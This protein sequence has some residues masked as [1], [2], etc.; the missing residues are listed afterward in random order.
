MF[1]QKISLLN[2]TIIE[3]LNETDENKI[4][5]A[6]TKLANRILDASFG[7]VWFRSYNSEKFELIYK[8]P[9]MPYDPKPPRTDGLNQIAMDSRMPYYVTDV[10]AQPYTVEVGPYMK[11][12]VIIPITHHTQVY[13]NIVL[14][15]QKK[16]TFPEEKKILCSFIGNSV[17][18]AISIRRSVDS[19]HERLRFEEENERTRFIANAAHELRTPLAIIKGNVD[20]ALMSKTKSLPE[21]VNALRAIDHEVDRLKGLISDMSLLINSKSPAKME[22][23]FS[24]IDIGEV[25]ERTVDR[26]KA[27]ADKKQI[28]IDI[29]DLPKALVSGDR[30]YLEMLFSNIIKNAVVYGKKNGHVR[31]SAK[32]I[33]VLISISINDDGMG[34]PKDDISKIFERFYRTAA[35]RAHNNTGTGLGLSIAKWIVDAHDG[36]I[37]V[38]SVE[39]EGSTFKVNLPV[40]KQQNIT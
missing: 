32:K 33:G 25:I 8:T 12:F 20:L 14:C 27:L 40:A 24:K 38:T 5:S 13:G 1:Y 3:C 26:C 35:A 9:R 39:N 37:T 18:D 31:I 7:F 10:K 34:I 11:S 30:R 28:S 16:E 6:F 2:E 15:F 21:A 22:F 19:H 17:A 23:V 29:G 36:S 4:I